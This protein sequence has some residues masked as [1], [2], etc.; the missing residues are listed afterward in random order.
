MTGDELTFTCDYYPMSGDKETYEIGS[1]KVEDPDSIVISNVDLEQT[2]SVI[3]YRFTDIYGEYYW[4][5]AL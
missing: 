1:M 5:P 3:T 4:T 2:K